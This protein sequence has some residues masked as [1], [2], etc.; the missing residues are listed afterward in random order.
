MENVSNATA[1]D[2]IQAMS[3]VAA[4]LGPLDDAAKKRVLGWA[5]QFFGV[6]GLGKISS[7]PS[8][9]S[10][11]NGGEKSLSV[12]SVAELFDMADPQTGAEKALVISYWLQTTEGQDGFSSQTVNTELKNL[13]HGVANITAAFT[14]LLEQKLALQ[15]QKSGKSQQARKVYKLTRKGFQQVEAM[16]GAHGGQ[17]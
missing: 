16:I 13:G 11:D 17:K 6:G 10:N 5:C 9:E 15:I 3:A 1:G 2:E 12:G 14:D 4:A 8:S 7:A